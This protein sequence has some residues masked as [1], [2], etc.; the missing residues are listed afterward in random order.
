[1]IAVNSLCIK[2]LLRPFHHCI[3][4]PILEK[5]RVAASLGPEPGDPSQ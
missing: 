2:N 3:G 5:K 1:M 4:F